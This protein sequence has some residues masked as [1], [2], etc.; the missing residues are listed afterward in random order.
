M[1]IWKRMPLRM[2][3]L[4]SAVMAAAALLFIGAVRVQDGM[5]NHI[6]DKR[7]THLMCRTLTEQ[8]VETMPAAERA[9]WRELAE[10]EP[11]TLFRAGCPAPAAMKRMP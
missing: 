2:R 9:A 4:L 11:E 5:R 3:L 10:N 8:W 6:S 1:K 7:D